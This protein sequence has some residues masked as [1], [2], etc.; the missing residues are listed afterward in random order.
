MKRQGG[1][2][3]I[4]HGSCCFPAKIDD[5][6][7]NS[8]L[9]LKYSLLSKHFLGLPSSG[10]EKHFWLQEAEP[11]WG[12]LWCRSQRERGGRRNHVA[13]T[14]TWSWAIMYTLNF[15]YKKQ[16]SSDYSCKEES[17]DTVLFHSHFYDINYIL[18]ILKLLFALAI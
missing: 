13:F 16:S 12:S 18:E 4:K 5:T 7:L 10:F 11:V 9:F 1:K 8:Y 2:R 15:T 14:G 17:E 3:E 6:V